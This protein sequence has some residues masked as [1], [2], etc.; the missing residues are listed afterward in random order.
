MPTSKNEATH[1]DCD[2]LTRIILHLCSWNSA[3]HA[4]CW[5]LCKPD[6]QPLHSVS[7]N[8][9]P[10]MAINI[11]TSAWLELSLL[12]VLADTWLVCSPS[13]VGHLLLTSS[14]R[15]EGTVQNNH[16]FEKTFC[17]ELCWAV[18]CDQSCM[19]MNGRKVVMWAETDVGSELLVTLFSDV[20]HPS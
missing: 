5:T 17:V 8:L 14:E 12:Q 13:V 19:Q 10:S 2:F 9:G 4:Y 3:S 6:G 11:F 15:V 18:K 7:L 20:T 16:H 1:T